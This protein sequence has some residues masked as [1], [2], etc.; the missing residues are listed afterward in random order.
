M[1][2]VIF[3]YYYFHR[4]GPL[5]QHW[6]MRFEAKHRYFKHMSSIIGNF[7]N[8]CYSLS[9]RHQCY[10]NLN[11]KDLPGEELDVGPGI[12]KEVMFYHQI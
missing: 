4:Y 2:N 5:S 3:I 12:T 8:I 7:T 10:L 6:T 9:L 11:T 1:F